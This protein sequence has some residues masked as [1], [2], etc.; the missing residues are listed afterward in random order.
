MN[1]ICD[2]DMRQENARQA[3][4]LP[5]CRKFYKLCDNS[6]FQDIRMNA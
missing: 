5:M 2:K 1:T 4:Q 6:A 3:G